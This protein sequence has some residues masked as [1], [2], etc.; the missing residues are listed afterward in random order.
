MPSTRTSVL[1]KRRNEQTGNIQEENHVR[2]ETNHST[3]PQA[4]ECQRLAADHKK[5]ERP[6]TDCLAALGRDQSY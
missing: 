5:H 3:L 6:G 2:M 4:E 1:T